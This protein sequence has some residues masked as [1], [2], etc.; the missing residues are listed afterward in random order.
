M[1]CAP[2]KADR[3]AKALKDELFN[4]LKNPPTDEEIT[5]AKNGV[6]GSHASEMQRSNNQA[7]N[8]ALMELYGVGY[9]ELV[10]YTKAIDAVTREDL[11]RVAGRLLKESELVS[12]RVG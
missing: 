5:R 2:E 4:V 12:V 3:A 9:D 10:T 7:M 11:V 1:A 8:M 6:E